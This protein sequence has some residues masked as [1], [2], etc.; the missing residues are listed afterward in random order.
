MSQVKT[1]KI[2]IW[3]IETLPD[4]PQVMKVYPGISAYPGL[5]LKASISS[6]ICV[7]WK[8]LGSKRLNCISAWDFKTRWQ[9]N[10]NDDYSVC[11]AAYAVLKDADCIVTHNGK[12]FDWKHLQTRL[13][14]NGL[15]TLPKIPHIDTCSVAKRHLLSFNNRLNTLAGFLS[16]TKKLEHEGWELW[17]KVWKRNHAAMMKMEKYCI[18]DVVVLEKIFKRLRPLMGDLPRYNLFNGNSHSCPNCGNLKL[19][20]DGTCTRTNGLFQRYIC[21]ECGTMSQEKIASH[22]SKLKP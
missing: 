3:D 4:F 19:T 2:I 5:T 22:Q 10:V 7:G 1:P 11:K 13:L 9:K 18:Q 6:I 12:R 20:R 21:K 8:E 14:V 17:E 15:P 16:D